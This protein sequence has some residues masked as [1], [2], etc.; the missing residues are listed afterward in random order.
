MKIENFVSAKNTYVNNNCT[1]HND[2]KLML[3]IYTKLLMH[4]YSTLLWPATVIAL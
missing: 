3:Y 1:L 4:F 2:L